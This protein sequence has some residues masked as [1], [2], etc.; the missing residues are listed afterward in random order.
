MTKIFK[1]RL[2][3]TLRVFIRGKSRV[4]FSR[5]E[6]A[7]I[8]NHGEEGESSRKILRHSECSEES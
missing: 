4:D 3:V 2:T 8:L 1:N 7:V 5:P 6:F